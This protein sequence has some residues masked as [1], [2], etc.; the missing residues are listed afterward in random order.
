MSSFTRS[1]I[2]EDTGDGRYWRVYRSFR[3]Y[4]YDPAS[5]VYVDIPAGFLTDLASIPRVLRS[6][7]PV[8]GKGNAAAVVH[9]YL[10]RFP[11]FRTT[12]ETTPVQL[13]RAECDGA[14]YE[15][16]RV[17][18][19]PRLRARV[20]HTGVRAGGWVGWNRYRRRDASND[21]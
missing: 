6:I 12:A 17:L 20:M 10:Y 14:F 15:A 16:L 18:G 8:H 3:F 13:S 9:D 11:C 7:V 5:G 2:L 1:L 21:G 4:R 19:C